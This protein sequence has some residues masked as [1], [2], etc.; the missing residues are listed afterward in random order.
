MSIGN[1]V[2]SKDSRVK[3]IIMP[4]AANFGEWIQHQLE[5][6]GMSQADLSRASGLATSHI[7]NIIN[8]KRG[9]SAE[10]CAM[11]AKAFRLT[12]VDVMVAAGLPV[13]KP[14]YSIETQEVAVIIDALSPEDRLLVLEIVRSF[15]N[16]RKMS[17]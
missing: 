8:G 12:T 6:R 2:L 10:S 17:I 16:R 11:I 1:Y 7:A 4:M 15:A 9:V 14:R 5:V 3:M 13:E